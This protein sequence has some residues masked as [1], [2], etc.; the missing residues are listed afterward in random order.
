MPPG[1]GRDVA[2]QAYQ[3]ELTAWRDRRDQYNTHKQRFSDDL[4]S[5][6]QRQADYDR[7]IKAAANANQF[8]VGQ[9][10]LVL[11]R[12]N[13][14]KATVMQAEKGNYYVTYPGYGREWDEWVGP[15]RIRGR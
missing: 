12:G 11:W 3:R 15:S 14:Y 10:V 5:F 6:A 13:W 8:Q 2:A 1:I 7:R 4:K 9:A